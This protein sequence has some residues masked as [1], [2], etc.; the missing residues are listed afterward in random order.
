MIATWT[1]ISPAAMHAI[2]A[3]HNWHVWGRFAAVRYCKNHGVPI[4]LLRLARQ[5]HVATM[6]GF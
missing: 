2:R 3:S 1:T 5:L 4:A 6:G